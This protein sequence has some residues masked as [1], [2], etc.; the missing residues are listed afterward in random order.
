MA[1][2]PIC[3]GC[4][5]RHPESHEMAT[6]TIQAVVDVVGVVKDLP[7]DIATVAVGV[8]AVWLARDH[9]HRDGEERFKHLNELITDLADTP[10][11]KQL[12]GL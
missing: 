7:L 3:P 9:V 1:L 8:V 11:A 12:A 10:K 6:D 2:D 4:G 5:K